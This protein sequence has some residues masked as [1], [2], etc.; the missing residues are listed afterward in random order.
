MGLNPI[1]LHGPSIY[2]PTTM[3]RERT[4]MAGMSA[5]GRGGYAALVACFIA[6][7][8]GGGDGGGSSSAS[9]VQKINVSPANVSFAAAALGSPLPP[10]Q[11]VLVTLIPNTGQLF[12]RV[13][14]TGTAVGSV[15][16]VT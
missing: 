10:A 9:G 12:F 3:P 16:N 14:V 2:S 11:T 5:I 6:G 7:C 1:C 15:D 13:V 8:H 4:A